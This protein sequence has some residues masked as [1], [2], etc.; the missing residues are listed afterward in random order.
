M[1]P[2]LVKWTENRRGATGNN[3]W[4]FREVLLWKGVGNSG[5]VLLL[6]REVILGMSVCQWEWSSSDGE[7]YDAWKR[8]WKTVCREGL[9]L[10]FLWYRRKKKKLLN[11]L[12]TGY[13]QDSGQEAGGKFRNHGYTSFSRVHYLGLKQKMMRNFLTHYKFSGG[14]SI[15][16]SR[17]L[18]SLED[19]I[20]DRFFFFPHDDFWHL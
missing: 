15:I 17:A 1:K 9:I 10:S 18:I 8:I 2:D 5:R 13:T 11:D 16:R 19:C 20:K 6:F 3:D 14:R 12:T 7:S 4:Q